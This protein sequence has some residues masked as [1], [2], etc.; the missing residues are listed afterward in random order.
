MYKIVCTFHACVTAK[1]NQMHYKKFYFKYN[2]MHYKK[3]YFKYNRMHY[4][5]FYFFK[6]II[7]FFL[8]NIEKVICSQG[9]KFLKIR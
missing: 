9:A 2:Q 7:K 3:N 1:Y 8:E 6:Y 4:K 5:K